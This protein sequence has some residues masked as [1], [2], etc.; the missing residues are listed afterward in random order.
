VILALYALPA[1]TATVSPK[2]ENVQNALTKNAMTVHLI[3]KNATFVNLHMA[4]PAQEAVQPAKTLSAKPVSKITPN[5]G[6]VKQGTVTI[7]RARA[8]PVLL[9]IALTVEPTLTSAFYAS[10]DLEQ[11]RASRVRIK[12]AHFVRKTLGNA[13]SALMALCWISIPINASRAENKWFIELI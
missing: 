9:R 2:P 3:T 13:S 7:T 10:L 5:A 8:L 1:T 11:R 4:S 12:I 6:T